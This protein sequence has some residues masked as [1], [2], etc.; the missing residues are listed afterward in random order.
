MGLRAEC[1][2]V[3]LLPDQGLKGQR[4]VLSERRP[5]DVF[6]QRGH[7]QQ[8]TAYDLAVTSGLTQRSVHSVAQEP[9]AIFTHYEDMKCEYLSTLKRCAEQGLE[10]SPLIFE[11]HSG[12]FSPTVR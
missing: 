7:H 2:K 9:A 6:L 5:A 4:S 1:E 10:F 3:G 11:A 12:S 8:P